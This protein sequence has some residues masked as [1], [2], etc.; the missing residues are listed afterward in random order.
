MDVEEL[1]EL[2]ATF[3]MI[4]TIDPDPE[5]STEM[6]RV[7]LAQALVGVAE[8]HA[9]RAEELARRRGAGP[10]EL[11][12]AALMAFAGVNCHSH[13]EELALIN[14]RVV[15]LCQVLTA[16]DFPGPLPRQGDIGSGDVLM[17]T[18]RLTAAALS[19]MTT[20]AYTALNPHRVGGDSATAGQALSKAM[21][22]LEDA[23]KD[24]HTHRAIGELMGM[25]D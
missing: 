3:G 21:T 16:L 10:A 4:V 6:M 13:V 20:A 1:A 9:T 18:I 15:R 14:W 12:Q 22:A 11:G 19:G 7:Q 23:V 17:R 2:L 5:Q 25:T 24:V 8:G